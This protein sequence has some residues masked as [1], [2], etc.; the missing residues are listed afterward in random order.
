M[1]TGT[2]THTMDGTYTQEQVRRM[3]IAF[4]SKYH[5]VKGGKRRQP[6]P[7]QFA[8]FAEMVYQKYSDNDRIVREIRAIFKAIDDIGE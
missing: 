8:S 3:V 5:S 7:N 1:K 4:M 2:M 6:Q